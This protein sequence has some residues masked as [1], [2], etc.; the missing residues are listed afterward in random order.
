MGAVGGILAFGWLVSGACSLTPN[1]AVVLQD[2]NIRIRD[3]VSL[4]CLKADVRQEMG[5]LIVATLPSQIDR[6][7]V[8]SKALAALV[9]RRA[10][11]LNRIDGVFARSMTILGKPAQRRPAASSTA[12][13][14]TSRPVAADEPIFR[15]KLGA[16]D[17]ISGAANP[18]LRFDRGR[19]VVRAVADIPEGAYLGPIAFAAG[20]AVEAG[21]A[22]VI[23]IDAGAFQIERRVHV[24]QPAAPGERAFVQDEDG[25]VFAAVISSVGAAP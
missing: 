9:R 6:I 1:E 2:R 16:T 11:T 23:T 7:E 21:G 12:C 3:I 17:C 10:P 24:L 20:S 25:E 22:V 14:R 4:D 18:M 5:G 8:T 19:S 13:Y 15:D